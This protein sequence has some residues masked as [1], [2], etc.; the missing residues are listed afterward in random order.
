MARFYTTNSQ[1]ENLLDDY[2]TLSPQQ[3]ADERAR[4]D[5]EGVKLRPPKTMK[6]KRHEQE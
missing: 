2:G 4:L 5:Q 6:R 1:E 3:A